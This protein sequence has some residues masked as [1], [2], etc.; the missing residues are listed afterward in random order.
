MIQT[1]TIPRHLLYFNQDLRHL[2]KMGIQFS[3]LEFH[4]ISS[5]FPKPIHEM[6]IC[7]LLHYPPEQKIIRSNATRP[8]TTREGK[9]SRRRCKAPTGE[10]SPRGNAKKE[11]PSQ[12]GGSIVILPWIINEPE[13][14][15]IAFLSPLWGEFLPSF[16]IQAAGIPE[17]V[18]AAAA[19]GFYPEF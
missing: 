17:K 11:A 5:T 12:V 3:G 14:N 4:T 19:G 9:A 13:L 6:T 2:P 18:W 7:H 8:S 16:S 15:R 1:K 10:K